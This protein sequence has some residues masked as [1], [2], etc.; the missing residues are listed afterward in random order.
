MFLLTD[1][2]FAAD[3]SFRTIATWDAE[4]VTKLFRQR[5][6]DRLVAT[7]AISEDLVKRLLAWKHPG[8][9]AHVGEP[10]AFKDQKALEDI[11]C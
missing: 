5:L 8:F 10:I 6:L 2:G 3:G 11:A 1:G 9:S 4:R 7:K